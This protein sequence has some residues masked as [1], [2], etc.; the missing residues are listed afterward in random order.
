MTPPTS[1]PSPDLEKTGEKKPAFVIREVKLLPHFR[2]RDDLRARREA[3][4]T[5]GLHWEYVEK[6]VMLSEPGAALLISKKTAPLPAQETPSAYK[7]NTAHPT[8]LLLTWRQPELDVELIIWA[9]PK[10]NPRILTAYLPGTDPTNPLYLKTV[11]VRD[12]ANFLPGM[13][14]K[15]NKVDDRTYD[16]YGPCPR[17]RGRF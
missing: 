5:H 3:F 8:R 4:L 12:N 6:R 9:V 13:K 15:A 14:I 7:P 2:S 17:Y 11:S 10:R 16:L 1:I